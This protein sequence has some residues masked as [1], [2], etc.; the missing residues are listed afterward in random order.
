MCAPRASPRPPALL[1]S[2]T[3]RGCPVG[4]RGLCWAL[5][6]GEGS[7]RCF[8]GSLPGMLLLQPW[9]L[10]GA[11][12]LPQ[13]PCTGPPAPSW[14]HGGPGPPAVLGA[15]APGVSPAARLSEVAAPAAHGSADRRAA[16]KCSVSMI[17]RPSVSHE[18]LGGAFAPLPTWRQDLH[19][20][21]T[22][23]SVSR[24]VPTPAAWPVCPRAAG[25]LPGWGGTWAPGS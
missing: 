1:D 19:D 20:A 2:G 6:L 10:Q 17:V 11:E 5:R 14:T 7:P 13:G 23:E 24:A 4:G 15:A 8:P 16:Q 25:A 9:S 18:V 21:G 22:H 12:L 3:A